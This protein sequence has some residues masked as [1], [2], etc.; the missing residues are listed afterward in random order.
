MNIIFIK[1]RGKAEWLRGQGTGISSQKP[2]W[3]FN[4]KSAVWTL[5]EQWPALIC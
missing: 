5:A 4:L 2:Q 1:L 3:R